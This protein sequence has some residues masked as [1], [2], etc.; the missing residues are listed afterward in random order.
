MN[1]IMYVKNNIMEIVKGRPSTMNDSYQ[2]NVHKLLE[3]AARV[4]GDTEVI[5][6]RRLQG[7]LRHR[8]T[9]R[10]VYERVNRIANA[11][12]RE[13]NVAPGDIVGVLDWNDHRYY[14]SYFSLPSI[15]AVTLELNIRLHPTELGYIIKHTKPKGLLVDDSLLQLAEVLSKEHDFSFILVMSD[16]PVEEIK[17]NLRVLGY[18]ELLRS[19]SP[20][21]PSLTVDERSAA[22]AAFTSGTTGLP[23]GVFYSHR[24][25]ILHA[26]AVAIGNSLTPSDVG[27]QIV[28]MFHANAWGTP[29]ASTMMGMKMIYPGRYTPD[30]LVEHIVT[31]KVTV[32][33]GVPTILLEIVRRLQQMG[34]KTPGLRITSGGSE[35][36][37][38]LAKAFMEL[39]GRVIQGYGATETSPLVSMALPKAEL[40]EL[41]DIERFEKMK[42]GLPIFGAEVKVVDPITNQ[43]LP[44][45]GKSFGEIW[46]RGPWIAKEYYND[47]RSSERFTPDGWWRSGDVGVVDPLGYI[48]LV[49]RLKDVI[50]SGGEWISS[51][52]L[53]NFL[54]AHPY[55][56]EASVVGVPHPKWGERPLA[57][58]SLKPEYQSKDKEEVKK[59]LR[60]HLL[61]RFAKWQLPDDFIFVDEIPKTSVGKF[62]KEEIRSKYKDIYMGNG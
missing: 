61:K 59:E 23:K 50:K 30:T 46:L 37:S 16:K 18:E 9:Y 11:F 38:A 42:Q 56:R 25:I 15:G 47:P 24:S 41:S 33:A 7:G 45:D 6:D 36:P 17:T 55:V 12:E 60:E 13:L 52:D 29:F 5:S 57:V 39:G 40:K 43:E 58:V 48:R 2:L 10:Q 20:N 51:I 31:H 35:P 1:L 44:W 49:D 53:E 34:V 8:F 54:M 26:M 3:H 4:H 21:R 32:T 22:T 19:N 27:L 28:P 62:R 14:E